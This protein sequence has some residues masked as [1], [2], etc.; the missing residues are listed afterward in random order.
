MTRPVVSDYVHEEILQL[1]RSITATIFLQYYPFLSDILT[2]GHGMFEFKRHFNTFFQTM[3]AL[4]KTWHSVAE[5]YRKF[6]QFG[7]F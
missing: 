3:C 5:H 7:Q 4:V 2:H 6:R 1:F